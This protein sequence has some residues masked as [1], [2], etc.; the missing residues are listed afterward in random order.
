LIEKCYVAAHDLIAEWYGTSGT[1]IN[2]VAGGIVGVNYTTGV[3]KGSIKNCMVQGLIKT[4]LSEPIRVGTIVGEFNPNI[5][6][7]APVPD[8]IE[9]NVYILGN[10]TK[11]FINN[12]TEISP[13]P[14]SPASNRNGTS[15]TIPFNDPSSINEATY[16]PLDFNFTTTW[17]LWDNLN[18]YPLP[19]LKWQDTIPLDFSTLQS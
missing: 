13:I 10:G 3:S 9:S 2:A 16:S 5:A 15:L 7:D 17:K 11:L 4:S 8:G 19:L 12:S 6:Q 18:Q 14:E 1:N